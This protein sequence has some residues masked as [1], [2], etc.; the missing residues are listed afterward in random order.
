MLDFLSHRSGLAAKNQM[1]Y[2]EVG[3]P[4]LPRWE[5]MRICFYLDVVR[6]FQK[7]WLH[8]NWGYGLADEVTEKASGKSWGTFRR[9][10]ILEPL[11]M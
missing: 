4:S 10:R 7:K 5:T 9:E 6:S 2:L 1:W 11:H 8:N 3:R